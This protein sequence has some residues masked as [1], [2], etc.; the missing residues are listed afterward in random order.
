MGDGNASRCHSKA[1]SNGSCPQLL[2]CLRSGKGWAA[3]AQFCT[4]NANFSAQADALA[5]V[6]TLKDYTEWNKG[7][8]VPFPDATVDIKSFAID[9]ARRNVTVY[10][11]MKGTHTGDG[12]PV[13][14][15]YRILRPR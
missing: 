10:A 9:D 14:C 11:T 8:L 3:C 15:P 2:Q 5:D 1:C 13:P 4:P 7:I 6:K 12:G